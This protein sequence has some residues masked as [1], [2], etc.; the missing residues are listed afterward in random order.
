MITHT[1]A[2]LLEQDL[3]LSL[4]QRELTQPVAGQALL[5]LEWAGVCGS[6]LHV[7]RTGDWVNT[8]PATLGHEAVGVVLECPGGEFVVGTRVVVD[9]R[10]PCGDCHGCTQSANLCERLAWV[11]EIVPGGFERHA[12]LDVALLHACPEGL[13]AEIAVL[14]EPLAVAMHAV[15]RAG[16]LPESVL[17]IGYGPIG[18]LVHSEITRRSPHINVLVR[19]PNPMRLELALA[20]GARSYEP[21]HPMRMPLVVDAAGYATSVADSIDLVSN[22]GTVLVVAIPHQPITLDGQ[23]IVE[24]SLNIIGCNG[25]ADELPIAMAALDANPDR[26]RPL[27]T[28]AVLLE[29]L[30]ARLSDIASRPPAGKIVVR[31]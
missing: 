22:G 26:Y 30:V 21:S 18:A 19:E 8:W 20:L 25:F 15:N 29:D 9:S 13:E 28:E 3:T 10:V 4:G 31:L 7:I 14:A 27:I 11:G 24:R 17:L 1:D 16:R 6:D 5:R 12:V 2:L 23:G